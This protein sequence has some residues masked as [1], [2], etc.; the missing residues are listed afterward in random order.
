[1][2]WRYSSAVTAEKVCLAGYRKITI[3][4]AIL[5]GFT[6]VRDTKPAVQTQWTPLYNMCY[7]NLL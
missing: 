4:P 5:L 2:G 3:K 6:P 1:M 7:E